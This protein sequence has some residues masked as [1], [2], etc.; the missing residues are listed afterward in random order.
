MTNLPQKWQG[1]LGN[2][3]NEEDWQE[4][5]HITH[6]PSTKPSPFTKYLEPSLF[7]VVSVEQT[8]G[9]MSTTFGGALGFLDT[10]V[11]PLQN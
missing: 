6:H 9:L 7:F 5:V 2:E 3:Y 1:D 4:A 8:L 11:T 10:G